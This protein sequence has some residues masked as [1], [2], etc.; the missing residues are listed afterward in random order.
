MKLTLAATAFAFLA[1]ANA[2]LAQTAGPSPLPP[3]APIQPPEDK[4]YPGT[5]RLAVDATDLAHHIFR[6]HETIPV[7]KSGAMTLLYPEWL[8]GHHSPGGPVAMFSGLTLH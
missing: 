5:I 7:A 3:Q 1:A 6:A 8:P 4:P 2:P